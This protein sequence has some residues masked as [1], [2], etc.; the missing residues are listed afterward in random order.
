MLLISLSL[1]LLFSQAL[2]WEVGEVGEVEDL[3]SLEGYF[4]KVDC[5][6]EL[7]RNQQSY[8]FFIQV[9]TQD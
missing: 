6:T 4:L 5:L 2:V 7:P 1:A 9:C 8:S 3:R